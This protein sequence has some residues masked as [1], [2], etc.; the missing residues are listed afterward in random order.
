MQRDKKKNEITHKNYILCDSMNINLEN[1]NLTYI[2]GSRSVFAR[3]WELRRQRGSIAK[4]HNEI[5]GETAWSLSW[6][7]GWFLSIQVKFFK[8]K[9]N[10][11]E[12]RHMPLE[13]Y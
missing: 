4:G 3:G 13:N 2:V 11:G 7:Q 8:L 6:E 10:Y 9:S 12:N 1:A 5:W